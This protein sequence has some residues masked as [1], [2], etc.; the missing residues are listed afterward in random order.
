MLH[1]VIC[2][3]CKCLLFGVALSAASVGSAQEAA[4]QVK[5]FDTLKSCRTI[6]DNA[7]RLAC[8]DS[9]VSVV[10]AAQESGDIRIVD[11]EAAK[12]TRRRLFGFTLPDIGWFG[13]GKVGDDQK[14]DMLETTIAS[15]SQ[16]R[17]NSWTFQTQEG[18]VW[19]IKNAPSRLRPLQP[20]Q[21]VVFKQAALN[22]YFIR[23]DGQMGVKG[24]RIG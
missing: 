10:I 20:G 3:F 12:Q 15:V 16:T 1:P 6:A 19:Q 17:R 9:A 14:L 23:I 13:D 8:F 18:A 24:T 11:K 7:R 4:T 5:D 22:S 2:N 21:T